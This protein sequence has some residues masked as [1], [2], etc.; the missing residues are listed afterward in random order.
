[1]CSFTY[2]VAPVFVLIESEVLRGLRQQVGWTDGDGIFCP[3]GSTSNMYAM[4]LARYRLFPEVKS[5]GLWGLPRL[6]IF[7]S[8]EVRTTACVIKHIGTSSEIY[9]ED[10]VLR[11]VVFCE[12]HDSRMHPCSLQSHYS[13]KKGAA[14]LGFGTDSVI[15]VKVDNG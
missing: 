9:S 3:G 14:F 11:F 5:Q 15:F 1:M 10:W 4:N 7:T 13:V 12:P 6:A 2:E 8:P